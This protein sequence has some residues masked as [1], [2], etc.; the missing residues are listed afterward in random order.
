MDAAENYILDLYAGKKLAIK[1][2]TDAAATI[3]KVD[4]VY[5]VFLNIFF[6]FHSPFL[7]DY[8]CQAS[9]WWT[10]TTWTETPG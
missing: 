9:K 8:H 2:A 4:Q 7:I 5:R 3:L 6:E 10:K 1:L